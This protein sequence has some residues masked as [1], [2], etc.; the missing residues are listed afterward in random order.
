MTE[1]RRPDVIK[2]NFDAFWK[3]SSVYHALTNSVCS[4]VIVPSELYEGEGRTHAFSHVFWDCAEDEDDAKGLM[5][6]RLGR[7]RE[8]ID[9][10]IK[11]H[12]SLSDEF[13][14]IFESL[15][16]NN[17]TLVIRAVANIGQ[18]LKDYGELVKKHNTRLGENSFLEYPTCIEGHM[19]LL[20]GYRKA[21]ECFFNNE[22]DYNGLQI[23][24]ETMNN[25]LRLLA[26]SD[27]ELP[28]ENL[29]RLMNTEDTGEGIMDTSLRG[30]IEL[31]K[32]L[33][34]RVEKFY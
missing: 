32:E 19:F 12:E 30:R 15:N 34:K 26:S 11:T 16:T 27:E 9:I 14:N 18:L 2:D 10:I 13:Y 5:V 8:D 1:K 24:I 23:E 4:P 3:L 25:V 20:R 28:R 21:R 17:R 6:A 7:G 33:L 31:T 29:L 22:Q